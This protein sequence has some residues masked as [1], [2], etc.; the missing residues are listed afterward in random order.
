MWYW[1]RSKY[2]HIKFALKN[3]A[4]SYFYL[5]LYRTRDCI[6]YAARKGYRTEDIIFNLCIQVKRIISFHMFTKYHT[7]YITFKNLH[8]I[9][10]INSDK[11]D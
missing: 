9:I 11:F 3:L 6:S 8:S 5:L 4:Q 2:N 10:Y 1:I 7:L